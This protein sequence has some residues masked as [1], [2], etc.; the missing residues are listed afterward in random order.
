M[1][2][3]SV[4]VNGLTGISGREPLS[5]RFSIG[6][7]LGESVGVTGRQPISESRG[8]ADAVYGSGHDKSESA[9][10]LEAGQRHD[11]LHR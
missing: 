4:N 9:I 3:V 8:V 6:V 1:P 5:W 11:Q 2:N 10:V 7:A